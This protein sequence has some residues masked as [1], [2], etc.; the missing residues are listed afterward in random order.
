MKCPMDKKEM[1][2]RLKECFKK[3]A[4]G[5]T[6]LR[7]C[8]IEIMDLGLTKQDVIDVADEMATGKWK[9]EAYLCAVTAIG[10][11]FRYEE[12]HKKIDQV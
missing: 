3:C 4:S 6:Q 11:A 7:N 12:K 9:D 10:Q 1:R 8:V 2:K 5:R